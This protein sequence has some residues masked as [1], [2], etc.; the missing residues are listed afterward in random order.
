[1]ASRKFRKLYPSL[2]A[3]LDEYRSNRVRQRVEQ[4][5]AKAALGVIGISIAGAIALSLL[6]LLVGSTAGAVIGGLVGGVVGLVV[7]GFWMQ[8]MV[9]RASQPQTQVEA[10]HLKAYEAS[11]HFRKLDAAVQRDIKGTY[12][13]V[14][15]KDGKV[16]HKDVT[17]SG[18]SGVDWIVTSGL[19]AGDQVIVSGIQMVQEGA[20]AKA[21]PWQPPTSPATPE[22]SAS[23]PTADSE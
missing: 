12:V 1:M 19:A 23:A 20:P 2:T 5:M 16:A 7:G 14:V 9:K 15:G 8:R 11:R 22:S 18:T 6:G 10:L 21:T 17:T 4:T 13:L 3:Y